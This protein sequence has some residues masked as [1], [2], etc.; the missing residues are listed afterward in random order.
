MASSKVQCPQCSKQYTNK[1]ALQGRKVS[2]KCGQVFRM[3][4]A[5]IDAEANSSPQSDLRPPTP[6]PAQ[7]QVAPTAPPQAMP[8]TPA[9]ATMQVACPTC[10]QSHAVPRTQA[11]QPFTCSCGSPFLIPAPVAPASIAPPPMAPQ[12]PVA[13]A[14]AH[15][16]QAYPPA[17]PPQ[18]TSANSYWNREV[19]IAKPKPRKIVKKKVVY[20]E[21]KR[22]NNSEM[23]DGIGSIGVGIVMIM[24]GG[25]ITI[26]SYAAAKPGG[27]YW[28][29]YGP[30][31]WGFIL[32]FKGMVQVL[33]ND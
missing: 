26:G 33:N 18:P 4:G 32:L 6:I 19:Q 3:P 24:I 11:G 22:K 28:I 5:K 15:P 16:A 21:P 31:I 1:P 17:S 2:C 14:V 27:V 7:P 9:V 25:C 12:A 30:V 8:A 20:E 29:A 13:P 23:S 10:K